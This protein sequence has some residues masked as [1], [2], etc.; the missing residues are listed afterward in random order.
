MGTQVASAGC[1]RNKR[2]V[3]RAKTTFLGLRINH[4]EISYVLEMHVGE[5]EAIPLDFVHT[6]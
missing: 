3:R 4:K 6:M 1:E 5:T 2:L